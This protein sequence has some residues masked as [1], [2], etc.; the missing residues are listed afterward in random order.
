MTS[1]K[2]EE[3]N[4]Q[5]TD[6][7]AIFE[8]AFGLPCTTEYVHSLSITH[9]TLDSF[10]T[11]VSDYYSKGWTV[12]EKP[13]NFLRPH[14]R[15]VSIDKVR[16]DT[17]FIARGSIFNPTPYQMICDLAFSH[18]I[19]VRDHYPFLIAEIIDLGSALDKDKPFHDF[20][21]GYFYW[22]AMFAPLLRG[23]HII[24]IPCPRLPY[25]YKTEDSE[26]IFEDL[27]NN[28]E[29]LKTELLKRG[30]KEYEISYLVHDLCQT[31]A[32]SNQFG[33]LSDVSVSNPKTVVLLSLLFHK[34][35]KKLQKTG[36]ANHIRLATM[37]T[38]FFLDVTGLT[39]QDFLEM[40]NNLDVFEKW[41][42]ILSQCIDK[43]FIGAHEIETQHN[44]FHQYLKEQQKEWDEYVAKTARRSNFFAS[45]TDR[46]RQVV[47][48]ILGGGVGGALTGQESAAV[49]GAIGG[50]VAPL[51]D[52]MYQSVIQAE[53]RGAIEAANKHFHMLESGRRHK[54]QF[55]DG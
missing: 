49:F 34:L 14:T 10:C 6:L 27:I 9:N 54:D 46:S 2:K 28:D 23:G 24:T 36:L 12:P 19:I 40:R 15:S 55:F 26:K 17:F 45:V 48:G 22:I 42:S 1:A 13:R 18:Q 41:R 7:P 11:L 50:G 3:V 47:V 29:L 8:A 44:L 53:N 43:S 4:S 51:L 32:A 52:A 30:I 38:G 20:I 35:E 33:T 25:I 5:M 37:R 39:V 21:R 16:F 31:I